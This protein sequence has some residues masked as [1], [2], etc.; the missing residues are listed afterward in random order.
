VNNFENTEVPKCPDLVK[1]GLIKQD[2]TTYKQLVIGYADP[3]SVFLKK[4]FAFNMQQTMLG[5]C[6][7]YK[8]D[9]C[10]T[11]SL[12]DKYDTVEA[13]WLST[14]LSYLVDQAKQGYWF[15]KDDLD[16]FKKTVVKFTPKQP[17]YK[18][19]DGHFT[20]N[21]KHIIDKLMYTARQ[22]IKKSITSFHARLPEPPHWDE[23]LVTYYKWAREKAERETDWKALLDDLDDDVRALKAA[24]TRKVTPTITR[25][26]REE[27]EPKSEYM[28][29]IE[30]IYPMFQA[31]LPKRDNPL[32]QSLVPDCFEVERSN[33]ALLKASALFNSYPKWKVIPKFPWAIAGK[34]LAVLKCYSRG[35]FSP[36]ITPSMFAML[37]PDPAYVRRAKANT[38]ELVWDDNMSITNA[39]E[40]EDLW[41]D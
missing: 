25:S 40:I 37:K 33:W 38:N 26:F 12:D 41:D 5:I 35:G 21:S 19:K 18:N 24:W 39:D 20:R 36:A 34:Q 22:T 6:T 15:T 29:K 27:D 30:E 4:A 11:Q 17:L 3:T 28:K 13:V 31:I 7:K 2:L 14:L 16:Y 1:E 23:D 10:Y 8:E 9:V 32:S